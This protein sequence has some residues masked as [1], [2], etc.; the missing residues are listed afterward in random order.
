MGS[1][2]Q[3]KQG[4]GKGVHMNTGVVMSRHVTSDSERRRAG[5]GLQRHAI[6]LAGV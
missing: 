2:T 1:S 5:R 6:A 4:Q 3:Y